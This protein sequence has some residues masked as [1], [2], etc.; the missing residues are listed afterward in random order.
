MPYK[1]KESAKRS[2]LLLPLSTLRV[3][4]L[5]KFSADDILKYFFLIFPRKQDLTFHANCLLKC[6]IL[7]SGKN[8]KNIINLSSAEN[9]Q[10]VVKVSGKG[11]AILFIVNYVLKRVFKM[12][13]KLRG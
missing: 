10:R 5:G 9:A 6:Q 13:I 3:S 1:R 2:F 12:T 8:K 4:T 11:Q 7:F